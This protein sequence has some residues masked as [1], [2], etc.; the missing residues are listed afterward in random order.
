M[1]WCGTCRY[2]EGQPEDGEMCDQCRH[3]P[4]TE[5]P[6]MTRKK[7]LAEAIVLPDIRQACGE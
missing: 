2:G 7:K 6:K 5:L 1:D 3:N 4:N